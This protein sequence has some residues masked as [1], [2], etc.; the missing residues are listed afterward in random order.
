MSVVTRLVAFQVGVDH[1]S[2]R[3]DIDRAVRDAD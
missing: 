3:Q 2:G 1:V